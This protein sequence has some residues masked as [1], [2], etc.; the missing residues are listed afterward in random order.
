LDRKKVV[1]QLPAHV[2]PGAVEERYGPEL[3]ALSPI[4]DLVEVEG[5]DPTAFAQGAGDADAIITSWGIRFDRDIIAKLEKCVVI[6][7]G[8]VGVDMVD[9]AAATEAGIVVTNVPDVFIEEVADHAMMLLLAAGRRIR[10]ME[11]TIAAGNWY[12]GRGI[13]EAVP[14]LMGQTL[15]LFAYGNIARCTARRALAFG[16]RVIA[17]DPYVSELELSGDGVEPVGCKALLHRSD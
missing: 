10:V 16:M 9:I 5:S 6:G 13:L 1:A 15:G 14:R 8:S 4:A 17:H 3:E 7:V 2:R 12:R 11:K